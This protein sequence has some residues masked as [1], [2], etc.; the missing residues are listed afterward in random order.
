MEIELSEQLLRLLLAGVAGMAIGLEREWREKAAGFR[1]MALVSL[2]SA[3]FVLVSDPGVPDATARVVAGVTTGVGFLGAGTILRDRGQVLGLT[4]AAAVWLAAALGVSSAL[5][6][7]GFTL[8]LMVA[9]LGMLLISP[10]VDLSRVRLDSRVYE[11][12]YST[13]DW[14]ELELSRAFR[15]AG[16]HAEVIRISNIDGGMTVAW[17]AY[18]R[19]KAHD[20]VIRALMDSD[21]VES[22]E[23]E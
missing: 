11:V 22:F 17:R 2:G 5:G 12:S 19:Q 16:V 14:D 7:Y 8:A 4:T 23:I 18:G 3:A 21:A 9:G 15:D 20:E 10:V 1:T 13:R 6:E